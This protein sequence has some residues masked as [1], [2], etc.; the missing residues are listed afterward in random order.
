MTKDEW[1]EAESLCRAG[2]KAKLICDDFKV[3]LE[4]R[5]IKNKIVI[6]I[7]VNGFMKGAWFT[8]EGALA[9]RIA[10]NPEMKFYPVK[11]RLSYCKYTR[12][13]AKNLKGKS[14]A[15]NKHILTEKSYFPRATATSFAQIKKHLIKVCESIELAEPFNFNNNQQ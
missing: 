1:S 3:T 5:R 13:W 15:E 6:A 11:V 10:A 9:D 7:F 8:Y 12:D 4:E 14:K 2:L